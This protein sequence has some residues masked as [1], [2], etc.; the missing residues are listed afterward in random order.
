SCRRF[1]DVLGRVEQG[2]DLGALGLGLG[3]PGRLAQAAVL[4]AGVEAP[5]LEARAVVRTAPGRLGREVQTALPDDLPRLVRPALVV[6]AFGPHRH[7]TSFAE[8]GPITRSGR[9]WKSSNRAAGA[10]IEEG[11]A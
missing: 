6:A 5:G 3:R 7:D 8:P 11:G 2:R 10:P 1:H 4:P 9:R